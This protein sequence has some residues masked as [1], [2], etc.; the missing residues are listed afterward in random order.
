MSSANFR[1]DDDVSF[2]SFYVKMESE[3]LMATTTMIIMVDGPFFLS[4]RKTF[5]FEPER[6]SYHP[7]LLNETRHSIV[8]TQ[9]RIHYL[10]FACHNWARVLHVAR[11]HARV[12][13]NPRLPITTKCLSQCGSCASSRA[14]K[15]EDER[16]VG[17][18]SPKSELRITTK[19]NREDSRCQYNSHVPF[20]RRLLP[21]LI[22]Q[23]AQTE[24]LRFNP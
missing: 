6:A 10:I 14:A 1:H 8:F 3:V 19:S 13:Q 16:W 20:D 2:V 11:Q 9:S 21:T 12:F 22:H 23:C 4:D 15:R 17:R 5:D 7:D 24:R 18:S